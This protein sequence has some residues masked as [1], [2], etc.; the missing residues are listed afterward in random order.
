[1]R[2]LSL[3]I[4][5]KS[6]AGIIVDGGSSAE[7]ADKL[8]HYLREEAQVLIT[9]EPDMSNAE[10]PKPKRRKTTRRRRAA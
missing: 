10:A 4:P 8:L 3:H 5:E 9:S 7:T 6:R 1:M 2:V